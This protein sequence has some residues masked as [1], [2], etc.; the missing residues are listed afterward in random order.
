[1]L[2]TDQPDEIFIGG[3]YYVLKNFNLTY[4][5]IYDVMQQIYQFIFDLKRGILIH[6]Q[7]H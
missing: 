5:F 2:K 3:I 6:S 7:I 4:S 1:M